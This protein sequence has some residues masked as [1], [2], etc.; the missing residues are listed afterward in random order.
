MAGGLGAWTP[1]PSSWPP[2]GPID[3]GGGWNPF[4]RIHHCIAPTLCEVGGFRG[5]ADRVPFVEEFPAQRWSRSHNY[6]FSAILQAVRGVSLSPGSRMEKVLTSALSWLPQP[7]EWGFA[8]RV[9]VCVCVCVYACVRPSQGCGRV[10]GAEGC[11]KEGE[12]SGEV[13]QGCR[14]MVRGLG[15][16]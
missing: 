5:E 11:C 1:F 3:R 14:Q 13:L 15:S 9:C 7:S 12:R 10:V 8:R 4:I 6:I 16:P 2:R